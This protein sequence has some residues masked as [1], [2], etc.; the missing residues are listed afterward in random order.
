MTT[1]RQVRVSPGARAAAT[2][3]LDRAGS[4]ADKKK[5]EAALVSA[6]GADGN[7][8]LSAEEAQAVV[9]SFEQA[10]PGPG[11]LDAAALGTGL[12][13][14]QAAVD[15]LAKANDVDG[16][17]V[18]FTFQQ[19][20]EKK[21]IGELKAAVEGAKGQ[22]LDVN[23]MIFEFQSDNIEQA[24]ADLASQ[25]PNVTFRIIGDSGQASPTGGNALPSL[26]GRDLPNV[27]VKFKK[28]FPY[29]WSDAK[30]RP[31]YDHNTT[32]G[33]NHHKGFATLLNGAPDRLVTGSFN[34]S[35]T[36]DTKNY[37][38]LSTY[39]AVDSSTRDATMAYH[40][41]FSAFWNNPDAALSPNDFA[42]FKK[43]QM[44]AMLVAH[45][46]P[47]SG[48]RALPSD[49]LPAYTLPADTGAADVNGL[50]ARDTS[51]LTAALGEAAAK[52]VLAERAKYGRFA[53]V[54]ELRER[55]PQLA[56][57]ARGTLEALRFG[58]GRV[59]VNN[60]TVEELDAVGFS[61]RDAQKIVTWRETKGDFDTIDQLKTEVKVTASTFD[62]VKGALDATDVEAFFNSRPFSA[63]AGG[64][65]YGPGGTRQTP[66]AGDT[67]AIAKAP[68]SVVVAATD[69]FNRATPATPI[70]VAMYGMSVSSPEYQSLV[71]AARR[72]VP[73]RVVLN[74]DYTAST[75]AAIK[76]L[77][78]QGLPIDVRVQSAKTMH[79]KFGVVGDDVF[80]GSANFSESSSTKHSEDRFTIKN[81][82]EI[83]A[84]F[85]SEFELLWAKSRTV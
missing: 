68:A 70:S 13:L 39:H 23:M 10:A 38:D 16:L 58:S 64:T 77:R 67:G 18:D 52:A 74:S 21:L 7:K 73:V 30:G 33:L 11:P 61:K 66:V 37:E 15:G 63:A 4:A 22:P 82:R 48:G 76:R 20:L 62:R 9:S 24:I 42:N 46:K 80:S 19:S 79:E 29:V 31:V 3:A 14:A 55:V 12:D 71:A 72:G 49:A 17:S 8:V 36:A 6:A 51:R 75:V 81:Q 1:F 69:L 26:L 60:A 54:D 53:S 5:V 65:G 50:R 40:G 85:Q 78:D 28:D 83:A 84:Q 56:Q 27:Q 59:S 34:W 32:M 35:T 43:A 41:E 57:V 45:G 25:N 44:D 2:Q 47:P